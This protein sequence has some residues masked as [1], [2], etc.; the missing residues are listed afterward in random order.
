MAWLLLIA[1]INFILLNTDAVSTVKGGWTTNLAG[2]SITVGKGYLFSRVGYSYATRYKSLLR[3]NLLDFISMNPSPVGSASLRSAMGFFIHLIQPFYAIG[4]IVTSF[5]IIFVSA[6]PGNRYNV[7][8]M[9]TKL[10]A[11]MVVI[12]LSPAILELFLSVS[13]VLTGVILG[14]TDANIFLDV[15]DNVLESLDAIFMMLSLVDPSLGFHIMLPIMFIVW[16]IFSIIFLRYAIVTMLCI[17]FPLAVFLYSFEFTKP[18]GRNM[19]EQMILWTAIQELNAVVIVAITVVLATRPENFMVIKPLLTP[20]F[21]LLAL[22]SCTVFI[23][24]PLMVVR[25]FRNFLP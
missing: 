13:G 24:A 15:M 8:S 6:S 2:A 20:N 12:S 9:L 19:L 14:L 22:A 4:I 23:V 1:A 11:G 3:D 25:L 5:Y 17:I 10:L 18:L 21:D 7:K 16:G